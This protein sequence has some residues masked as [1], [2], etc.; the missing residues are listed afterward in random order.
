M[1]EEF[2]TKKVRSKKK[3]DMENEKKGRRVNRAGGGG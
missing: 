2:Q 3:K 1:P